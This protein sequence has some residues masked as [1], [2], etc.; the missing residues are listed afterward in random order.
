VDADVEAGGAVVEA[1]PEVV[2][3]PAVDDEAV[4]GFTADPD[5]DVLATG[6]ELPDVDALLPA[7]P[8]QPA[9]R[10]TVPSAPAANRTEIRFMEPNLPG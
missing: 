2:T 5:E 6:V 1:V 3:S 7:L 10:A 8:E 9:V 4:A